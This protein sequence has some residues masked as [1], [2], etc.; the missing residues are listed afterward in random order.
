[1]KLAADHSLITKVLASS[2]K[3]KSKFLSFVQHFNVIPLREK[4]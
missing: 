2:L 4:E 1:M 3:I